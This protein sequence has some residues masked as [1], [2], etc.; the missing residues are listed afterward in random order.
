MGVEGST[1][2]G[3]MSDEECS[4]AD[5]DAKKLPDQPVWLPDCQETL[6]LVHQ[7]AFYA[8]YLMRWE[9]LHNS[10]VFIG[11][12]EN[13]RTRVVKAGTEERH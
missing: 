13:R 3:K 7:I 9:D 5:K 6:F 4:G 1:P 11:V 2:S 10:C 12:L 8:E